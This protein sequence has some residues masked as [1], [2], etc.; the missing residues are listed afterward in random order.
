MEAKY[1][2]RKQILFL[3]EDGFTLTSRIEGALPQG[4]FEWEKKIDFFLKGINMRRVS[5]WITDG[6]V[7]TSFVIR[8]PVGR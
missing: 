8:T 7:R 5:H 6:A 1:F 3:H 4:D 2:I